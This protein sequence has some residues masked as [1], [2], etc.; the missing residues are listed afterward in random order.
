MRNALSAQY[1]GNAA[2]V[3]CGETGNLKRLLELPGAKDLIRAKARTLVVTGSAPAGWPTPV[4]VASEDFGRAILFPAVSI[5]EQFAY[6]AAHP[7]PIAY[8]A[9]KSMPYDATTTAM[10]AL[11]YAATPEMMTEPVDKEAIA[12]AYTTLA[13]MKP[14]PRFRRAVVVEENK[15]AQ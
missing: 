10:S 7:I 5:E 1:D 6:A 11:L 2:M 13:S 14:Q 8:R 15:V 12:L 4:I 3:C 9:Y